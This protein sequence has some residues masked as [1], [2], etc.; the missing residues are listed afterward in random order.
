M[1]LKVIFKVKF[2]TKYCKETQ[3]T[4]KKSF[5]AFSGHIIRERG[6]IFCT[7]S[8]IQISIRTAQ[9]GQLHIL[10]SL[11]PFKNSYWNSLLGLPPFAV[12]IDLVL[13]L[14][15]HLSDKLLEGRG[16]WGHA[17]REGGCRG[18]AVGEATGGRANR[19]AEYIFNNMKG[20]VCLL[21]CYPNT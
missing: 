21:N 13:P 16:C 9:K 18:V 11:W 4:A 17:Y 5:W 2:I 6:D 14:L 12:E 20:L 7:E 15:C 19:R 8:I 3:N 10:W 1:W